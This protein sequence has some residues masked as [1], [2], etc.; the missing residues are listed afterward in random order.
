MKIKAATAPPQISGQGAGEPRRFAL[1]GA[2]TI[3]SARQ[4]ERA[5][6]ELVKR[7]RG[8]RAVTFDLSSLEL[9]DT[10]GALALNDARHALEQA[11]VAA[12]IEGASAEH[13]LLLDR[14]GFRET[15]PERRPPNAIVATLADLGEQIAH[16][17]RDAIVIVA[18]LG[19]F[20]SAMARVIQ[21]PRLFRGVSVVYQMESFALRSIPII[22]TINLTVGGIIAQQGIWELQRSALASMSSISSAYWCCASSGCCSPPS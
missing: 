6:Q 5:S 19:E 16:G 21:K 11:G 13:V 15:P 3:A 18:F 4:L 1:D 9:L 17:A 12:S 14:V 22:I 10:A 20:V 8:A 7:A 2:W